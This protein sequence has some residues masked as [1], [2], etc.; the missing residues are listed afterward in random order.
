MKI[1]IGDSSNKILS[2][3][4]NRM[5]DLENID[6]FELTALYEGSMKLNYAYYTDEQREKIHQMKAAIRG[7]LESRELI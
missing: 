7:E 6:D 2:F 4:E 5:L 1:K 3:E